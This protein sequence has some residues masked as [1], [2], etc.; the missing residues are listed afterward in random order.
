MIAA[1]CSY[2]PAATNPQ[3]FPPGF[4]HFPVF[5][6]S[7]DT[8]IAPAFEVLLLHASSRNADPSSGSIF[9]QGATERAAAGAQ[10]L[11]AHPN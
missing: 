6:S 7:N 11:T 3:L 4:D 8:F 5:F 2:H 10:K 9:V 1:S